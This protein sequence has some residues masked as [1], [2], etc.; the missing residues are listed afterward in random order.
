MKAVIM[1]MTVLYLNYRRV[2]TVHTLRIRTTVTGTAVF[3][4]VVV[5]VSGAPL[6]VVACKE[7]E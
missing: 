2:F 3:I 5:S 1:I 7:T 4:M 6:E